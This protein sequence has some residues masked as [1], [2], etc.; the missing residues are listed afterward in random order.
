[1]PLLGSPFDMHLAP[2]LLRCRALRALFEA[3]LKYAK[4]LR[5]ALEP[6]LELDEINPTVKQYNLE[7]IGRLQDF[8]SGI[9][10]LGILHKSHVGRDFGVTGPVP[11]RK[12]SGVSDTLPSQYCARVC[13]RAVHVRAG[14]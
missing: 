2:N 6:G 12:S 13:E 1:M 10:G 5:G 4:E 7:Q 14:G 11:L 3:Y 8:V 9:L